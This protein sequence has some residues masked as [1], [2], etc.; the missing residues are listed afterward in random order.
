MQK[1]ADNKFRIKGSILLVCVLGLFFF[2]ACGSSVD[3]MID[4]L[5]SLSYA[6][7]YRNLDSVKIYADSALALSGNYP[8]GKAEAYNNLAFVSTA[9]MEYDKADSLLDLAIRSSDNQVEL[10]VADVQYM[11]LCQR[12][13]RNKD[14]YEYKERAADRINRINEELSAMSAHMRSRFIYAKTEYSIVCSTYYYYVGLT[15]QSKNSL[16]QIEPFGEIQEDTAQYLNYLYQIG[17]GG[18][19]DEGSSMATNQKEFEYLFKC[20]V[21]S[22]KCNYVY[23]QANALQSISE[24]LLPKQGRRQLLDKHKIAFSF[25]NEDNMPDSLLAGYLAQKA[26]QMFSSYGDVYQIV[27]AYRTLS[28][29]YWALGDYTSSLICLENALNENPSVRQ[30]PD[31]VAS[32][33]ECL[34]MVYSAVDDKNN[35]DINRNEYLD[36]Q[37]ETRQDRQ[38]EA[39]AEQLDRISTQLN[40]L[41][42]VILVLI[43]AVVVLFYI[44]DKWGKK[45]NNG[46]YIDK[47]LEPLRIW[48]EGNERRND[49]IN[50]RYETVDEQLQLARLRLE[51]DK[52]RSL[53]NKAKV[54][55][56]NNVIPYIDRIIIEAGKLK[57]S[58]ADDGLYRERKEYMTELTDKINEYNDVLT[59]WIQ[60]QQGRI[61]LHIE[62]FNIKEIFDLLAKSGMSFQLKGID[63]KVEPLDAVV[64]ADKV[65]TMFMLN[66]LADNARKFTPAGGCVTV[67]ARKADDYVEISVSDNGKG[68]SQEELSGIFDHKIYNGHGFGLMNCKGIIEKYKKISQIFSVCGL[69][70]ESEKGRGSRFYFRLPYGFMRCVIALIGIFISVLPVCADKSGEI[71]NIDVGRRGQVL[72]KQ[73]AAYADSAYY[74][75]VNGTYKRTLQFADSTIIY[76]NEYYKLLYPRGRKFM[77]ISDNGRSLPA[78]IVWFHEKIKTDYDV[79]L[80]IRNECAVAALALHDW[81]LYMY[82]NKI[83]T[84]LFKER[85]ADK[86]LADYC[87]AMQESRT[88]KTIAIFI[89]VF[90]FVVILAAYYFLYYRHVLY[91]RFC[92]ENIENIN[93]ILLSSISNEEKLT[94]INNVDTTRYPDVLKGIIQKIRKALVQSVDA[95]KEKALNIELAEDELRR[96]NYETEKL[97]ISNNVIDNCL[98]TLKHETMYYPSR[99]R[100]LVDDTDRNIDAINEV[101]VYYKELYS[102]L[103][104]QI[105][106]QTDTVVYECRS[107]EMKDIVGIDCRVL[108]DKTL[109]VYL[110]DILKKYFD[111]K[112]IDVETSRNSEKY[113]IFSF[114]CHGSKIKVQHGV[115]YFMPTVE[116]IPLL[117]CRQIVRENGKQ[118]NLHGCGIEICQD[119]QD[120]FKI[121]IILAKAMG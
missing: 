83:Y 9:R 69:F 65:L 105:R 68:L 111:Y 43:V 114:L 93:R 118:T 117:I 103:C 39:R 53:D 46:A 31:L 85:S 72:L 19:L 106:R 76:L 81:E 88:N 27:G 42:V 7:H 58:S 13:S 10:L 98:S 64:K 48:E 113:L 71:G 104:E 56:V 116:N 34:S 107:V 120:T 11:R 86:G 55:L 25:I 23:W 74:S 4:G 54:F 18:I 73:A 6:W 2:S 24:H 94:F 40:A 21:L 62:S 1:R 100:Q 37:E 60:L 84:R 80:D 33:R 49:E 50:D 99:I 57:K 15:R 44:F 61:S 41:I 112:N 36:I 108:G 115:D 67:S 110:F 119:M 101:A 22:K 52:R 66:T 70:A 17:S 12:R 30:A 96:V 82:N 63:F 79:I 90:L 59:H 87:V 28:F 14:F 97:Y 35:S 29:C 45:N 8:A 75:N 121:K 16:K 92:V 32:I 47:L 3:G 78:E 109:I 51:R 89:L 95:E 5:N 77:S 20:Y 38:L 91:F 26:W 102:I